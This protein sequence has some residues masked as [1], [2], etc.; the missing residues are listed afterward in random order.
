[1]PLPETLPVP[2]PEERQEVEELF[3]LPPKDR[4]VLHLFYYEGYSTQD[5][6]QITGLSPGAVRS[7]LTRAREK[8]RKAMAE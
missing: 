5:I 6:A 8:L 1:M 2:G 7:R 3:S 4:A